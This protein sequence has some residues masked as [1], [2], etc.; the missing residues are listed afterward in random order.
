MRVAENKVRIEGILSETNLEYGSFQK[1]GKTV[2]CIRGLIKV[3]VNQSVNGVP[4]DNEIPVHMFASKLKNDGTPNPAYESIDR[5][6]REYISIAASENGEAGADC[7]RIT[8]AQITMNEYYNQNKQLV[9]F[10]R[11]QA[12]FVQ[13]I[14]RKDMKPEASFSAEMVVGTKGYKT[15]AEGN[16][17]EPRVY[18]VKGIM[19]LYGDKVQVVEFIAA[20]EKVADVVENNWEE[21]DTVKFI[22][23]LN[24]SSR[25]ETYLEE[26]DF[27]EPQERTRTLSVSELL[28]TGGSKDPLEGDFTFDKDDIQKALS[29]RASRLEAQKVKDI[30]R[31]KA[32]KAPAPANETSKGSFDLGF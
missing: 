5:I 8:S 11:I 22:G 9:S 26:V 3:L 32:R 10:P 30:E 20:N 21:K 6:K 31:A 29:D 2:E 24:F 7:V 13:K 23:R 14:A 27:G 16:E 4:T 12:S 17:V 25:T 18:S 1:D 19:P 28:I 15:D